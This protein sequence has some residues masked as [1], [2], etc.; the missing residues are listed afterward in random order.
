V[1]ARDGRSIYFPVCRKVDAG[2][3]CQVFVA[4]DP[5]RTQPMRE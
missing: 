1:W 2:V 3:D 5:E 4:R